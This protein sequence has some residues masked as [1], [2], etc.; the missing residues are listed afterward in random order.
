[1]AENELTVVTPTPTAIQEFQAVAEILRKE[2]EKR[3]RKRTPKSLRK[4][5]D[6]GGGKTVDIIDRPEYQRFLDESFPGWST[7]D[8]ILWA[9]KATGEGGKEFPIL[10]N[11]KVVIMVMDNGVKRK[12][13]GVGSAPVSTKELRDNT[14]LL[15]FKYS[16]AYTN[17]MKS[18]CNWL[19]AFF[20]LRADDEERSNHLSPPSEEQEKKY[21]SLIGKVSESVRPAVDERWAKQNKASA[22]KFLE[23]LESKLRAREETIAATGVQTNA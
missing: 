1:M 10:F 9:D 16:I 13:V 4:R 21:Q 17:A 19:G 22:D 5:L 14:A 23:E 15:R 12:I 3:R 6:V 11:C 7:E 20:D 8:C 18:A 2:A